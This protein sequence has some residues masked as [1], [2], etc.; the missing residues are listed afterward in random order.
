[1]TP[2]T[3]SSTPQSAWTRSSSRARPCR[4][5]RTTGRSVRRRSTN[6]T[7]APLGTAAQDDIRQ[8]HPDG[9]GSDRHTR[10]VCLRARVGAVLVLLTCVGGFAACGENADEREARRTVSR[11]YEALNRRDARTACGLVSP[12][13]ADAIVHASGENG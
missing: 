12:A 9:S 13:L 5:W 10:H 11:F 8:S 3:K 2:P 7:S 1:M 4:G 6:P